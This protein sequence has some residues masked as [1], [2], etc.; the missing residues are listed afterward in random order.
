MFF[1]EAPAPP[2]IAAGERVLLNLILALPWL[3]LRRWIL[4]SEG[5]DDDDRY[6]VKVVAEGNTAGSL[7]AQYWNPNDQT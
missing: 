3:R 1:R 5:H 7:I 6:F 2:H 4:T